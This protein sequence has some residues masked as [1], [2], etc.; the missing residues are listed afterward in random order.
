[1]IARGIDR[2]DLDIR[3]QSG[4]SFSPIGLDDPEKLAR[5]FAGCAAVAHLGGINREIGA[6]TYAR[7]HV[8]GTANVLEAA[9][10][11]GVKK[12]TLLSFLRARP[13]C[14]SP[15]HESKWAAEELVRASGLDAT[16]LKAGVIY[17]RGDHMLDHISHALHTFPIFLFVGFRPRFMRPLAVDDLTKIMEA[18][19][20]EGRLSGQTIPVTGPEELSL[21]EAVRRIANVIGVRRLM[22]PAP[23]AVHRAMAWGFERTMAVPLAAKAQVRILSES[24][25]EPILAPDALPSDLMPQTPFTP[26]QIRKG[27]PKPGRFGLKDCLWRHAKRAA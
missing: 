25:A 24:L 1:M 21:T 7:V 18:S 8:Q 12:V 19:L 2:R 17:G 15:Y 27:L 3:T 11:A 5:A 4:V 23:I 9:K 6:Q 20:V 22:F 16:L 14:G 10:S 26:E 13:D